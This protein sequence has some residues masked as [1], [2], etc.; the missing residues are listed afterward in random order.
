M[1]KLSPMNLRFS[2]SVHSQMN[3]EKKQLPQRDKKHSAF[4]LLGKR[5]EKNLILTMSIKIEGLLIRHYK[6]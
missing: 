6:G 4:L 2:L 1:L 3:T 5:I